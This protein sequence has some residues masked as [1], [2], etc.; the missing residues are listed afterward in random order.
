M[1]LREVKNNLLKIKSFKPCQGYLFYISLIYLTLFGFGYS[2]KENQL[3]DFT[4]TKGKIKVKV[5]FNE[6]PNQEDFFSNTE[7]GRYI[8]LGELQKLNGLWTGNYKL[9][10]DSI[11][12]I[13]PLFNKFK[14]YR[15]LDFGPYNLNLKFILNKENSRSMESMPVCS[16][17]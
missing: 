8:S 7:P 16:L 11:F 5:N 15:L 2:Y 13:N 9:N 4:D 3:V 14:I 10:Y 12:W 17:T 1:L 6:N